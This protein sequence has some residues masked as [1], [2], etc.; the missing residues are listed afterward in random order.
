MC[1]EEIVNCDT[2]STTNFKACDNC[3][4]TDRK[5]LTPGDYD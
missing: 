4:A 5:F 1:A 2:Y 3:I